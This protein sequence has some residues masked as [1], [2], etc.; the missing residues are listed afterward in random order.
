MVL[1]STIMAGSGPHPWHPAYLLSS[2][3]HS[4]VFTLLP[5]LCFAYQGLIISISCGALS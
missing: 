5:C 3:L 2:C 1:E 4:S